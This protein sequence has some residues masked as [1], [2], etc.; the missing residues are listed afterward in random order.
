MLARS[1]SVS[2]SAYFWKYSDGGAPE[3]AAL[4]GHSTSAKLAIWLTSLRASMPML[5][6]YARGKR[7]VKELVDA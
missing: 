2:R 3:I 4:S 7:G 5:L 1:P 6:R